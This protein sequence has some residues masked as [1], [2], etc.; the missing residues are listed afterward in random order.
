[1]IS[2][3]IQ[4][5]KLSK[6]TNQFVINFYISYWVQN[7]YSINIDD[8]NHCYCNKKVFIVMMVV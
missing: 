8:S 6:Q 7:E 3:R 2:M 4:T 5:A 1:M